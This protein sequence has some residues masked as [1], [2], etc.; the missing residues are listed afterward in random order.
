MGIRK[1]LDD[2][3]TDEM[4]ISNIEPNRSNPGQ[5]SSFDRPLFSVK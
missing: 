3:I 2:A 4:A 1:T 5:G